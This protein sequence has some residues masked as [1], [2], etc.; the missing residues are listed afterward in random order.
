MIGD[1]TGV[2]RSET[3]VHVQA[4]YLVSTGGRLRLVISGGPSFFNV[5]QDL[6]TEVNITEAYPYDTAT[7]ASAQKTSVKGS[8]VGFNVG[9][10]VMWMFGKTVGVGGLVR[11]APATVDLDAPSSR[12]ASVDAGGIYAGGGLRLLF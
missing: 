9:A 7:F 1:A 11:F 6:V 8:A 5:E 12:T 2:K 10:D 4:M 3:A